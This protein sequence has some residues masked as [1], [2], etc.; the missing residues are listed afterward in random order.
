[1]NTAIQL[2]ERGLV[3]EF[4]LRW[5]IRR[6][7][8]ERLRDEID[9]AVK[10]PGSPLA[11]FAAHMR[12]TEIALHTDKANEQHYEVPA[13][14]YKEV[15]GSHLKYSSCWY[16]SGAE[17]LSEAESAMLSLT[18]ERAELQDGQSVLELGCGWGSMTLE[19]ASRYPNSTI[20]SV[21]N[22]A[23]Q[24]EFILS[25]A[26]ARG[27][28]NIKVTTID[29]NDFSTTERFDR[30]VSV[31][32][33]EHV[34]NWERL[35]GRV[36]EWLND[37]GRVFLH[38]FSHRSLA[39]PFETDGQNDWMA[40]YFF[41]GGMMP[42]HGLLASLNI[43]FEVEEDWEVNGTNYARTAED[44]LRNLD[45][46]RATVMPILEEA[47]GKAEAPVWFRRWRMFFLACAELFGFEDGEEWMVSHYRL[48]PAVGS[49][50]Q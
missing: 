48:R 42:A 32:M 22:S 47:Y 38:V 20:H 41:T 1:M 43:P 40:R 45:M 12:S 17:T 35:L 37:D 39:Y 9:R 24:R 4:A 15:L 2:A 16:E 36:H 11:T 5:G 26:K 7:L 23:S 25:R 19:M 33:F 50:A 10:I 34:R 31:E 13:A 18:C 14:F 30:V 6:L 21:S 49:A 27:L 29:V 3:P 28:H 46:K 44:W 8:R